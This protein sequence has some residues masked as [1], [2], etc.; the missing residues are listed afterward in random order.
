MKWWSCYWT[1][2]PWGKPTNPYCGKWFLTRCGFQFHVAALALEFLC[3]VTTSHSLQLKLGWMHR[4]SHEIPA[5]NNMNHIEHHVTKGIYPCTSGQGHWE[6]FFYGG[7]AFFSMVPGIVPYFPLQIVLIGGNVVP[8]LMFPHKSLVQWHTLHH[9]ITADIYAGNIPTARD[10]A[11]S[12]CY[13]KYKANIDDVSP[14][15][16]HSWM[17]DSV[18]FVL[19]SSFMAE[20]LWNIL[21]KKLFDRCWLIRIWFINWSIVGHGAIR[22]R[23]TLW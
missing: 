12:V 9:V 10:Q 21:L 23:K 7:C 19:Q 18:T 8:H 11:T 6:T 16:R 13:Q 4:L 17:T 22:I 1:S 15:T 2:L 3:G 14:F 5:L 20:S